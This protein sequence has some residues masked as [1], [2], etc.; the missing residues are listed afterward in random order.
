MNDLEASANVERL[1][2]GG[3]TV[4]RER[5]VL[6]GGTALLPRRS[7]STTTTTTNTVRVL[8]FPFRSSPSFSYFSS[9]NLFFISLSSFRLSD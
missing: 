3:W 1:K 9:S 6:E 5:L 4:N 2:V 8:S 7:F